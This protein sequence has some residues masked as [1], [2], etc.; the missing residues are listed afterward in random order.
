MKLFFLTIFDKIKQMF[1]GK[2][3]LNALNR[4]NFCYYLTGN[5]SRMCVTI[6]LVRSL[7]FSILRDKNDDANWM[8][9]KC[10]YIIS[11]CFLL[12]LL[13]P[14]LTPSS[15]SSPSP[16]SLMAVVVLAI[17]VRVPL[18]SNRVTHSRDFSSFS[19]CYSYTTTT[20]RKP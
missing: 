2:L 7:S 14:L 13:L 4:E 17:Y 10:M 6:V 9:V 8:T 18:C 1:H 19:T 5:I 16:S 12:S 15:L 20:A 3:T 11:Y